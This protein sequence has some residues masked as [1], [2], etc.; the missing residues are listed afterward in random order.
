MKRTFFILSSSLAIIS[1]V[2]GAGF[3]TGG[4]IVYFFQDF[5][6]SGIILYFVCFLFDVFILSFSERTKIKHVVQ[7][8]VSACCVFVAACAFAG[9]KSLGKIVF[10]HT[11]NIEIF[12][13]IT[14][15]LAIIICLFG[16]GGFKLLTSIFAPFVILFVFLFSV[17]LSRQTQIENFFPSSFRGGALPILYAACGALL[18]SII[19]EDS[20][21]NATAQ[22]KFLVAAVCSVIISVLIYFV[23]KVSLNAGSETPLLTALIKMEKMKSA[24]FLVCVLSVFCSLSAAIYSALKLSAGSLSIPK[25]ITIVLAVYSFS[26]V[27][28]SAAISYFY[29]FVGFAGII[30]VIAISSELLFSRAKRRARTFRR[31]ERTI[32]RRLP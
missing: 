1:S 5:S 22:E 21:R 27:G 10:H 23:G 19:I 30:C 15:I 14:L 18:S 24:F 32:R 11:E 8:V 17:R 12:S 28:F 7:T 31:R 4:E 25:K 3:I 13:I 20:L 9:F 6:V 26:K 16:M 29:P 2:I